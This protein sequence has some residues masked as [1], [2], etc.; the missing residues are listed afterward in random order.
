ML[1]RFSLNKIFKMSLFIL[2][3]FLFSIYPKNTKYNLEIKRVNGNNYHDIFLIDKN[4][5]VSKTTIAV[6]SIEKEKLAYDLVTSLIV[7]GKNKSKIPNNFKAI[8]PKGTKIEKISIE[9]KYLTISFDE[10]ILKTN[11]KEK[12]IE[13]IVYTL[14][15]I[16]N[17]TNVRILINQKENEFFKS[18]YTREIGINK[19]YKLSS[20]N[21]INN[22]TI[23]YV[24][25]IN[26]NNYYIPVT[27]YINSKDDK[28]KVIIDELASKSSYQ[29]NLM[30]Y[31]N[32][33]T[34]LINYNLEDNE[35][36]LYFNDAIINS[37][38][39]K[40]LEEVRYS[41]SYSIKDSISVDNIH[42]FVN[43]KEFK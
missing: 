4:N 7:D 42:F 23:Y 13:A 29:S 20:L 34:K 18:E 36:S 37:A 39:D 1:K 9:N 24:S 40:I 2:V 11:N 6:S 16:K 38:D 32:Y 28:I 25:S 31:L 17:I 22:I 35:L 27:K 33:D 26:D 10:N 41:I 3:L 30:S 5:Y 19:E 8:I 12:M 15:S 14:T 21:D 43:D